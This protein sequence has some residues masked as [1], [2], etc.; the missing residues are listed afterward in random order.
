MTQTRH[1]NARRLLTA[2]SEQNWANESSEDRLFDENS[3]VAEG[4]QASRGLLAVTKK[5][6]RLVWG[7]LV[8]VGCAVGVTW[9]VY[10][11]TTTSPRFAVKDIQFSGAVRTTR[12]SLLK[13]TGVTL[14]DNLFKLNLSATENRLLKDPWIREVH[15]S[16]QLPSTLHVE[17]DE[18]EASAL[19]VLAEHLLLVTRQGEIFKEF[20]NEDPGDLPTITGVTVDD[21]PRDLS[22]EKQR[23]AVA[24][25]VLNHYSQSKLSR[26]Y[27]PQEVHLTPGGEIILTVGHKGIALYLG[28][29]PWSKKLVLAER[30]FAKLQTQRSTPSMVFLD[31]RAHPERV[32]VRV[33]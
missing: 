14:G 4:G 33:N 15:V 28:F 12:D 1:A 2:P 10:R 26:T 31:N 19:A 6:I 32:V 22:L 11:Y 3:Q 5:I 20:A 25:D 24:L 16:R 29:G 30:I 18:R 21:T 13:G 7:V 8:V 17:I 23:I 9:G 27:P